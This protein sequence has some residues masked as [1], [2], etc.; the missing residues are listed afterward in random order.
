[1]A[2]SKSLPLPRG[3]LYGH[4]AVRAV[5]GHI[6]LAVALENIDIASATILKRPYPGSGV[7][8]TGYRDIVV[9]QLGDSSGSDPVPVTGDRLAYGCSGSQIP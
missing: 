4:H 5:G 2:K 7:V 9:S 6:P 3:Y 8:T 1:M